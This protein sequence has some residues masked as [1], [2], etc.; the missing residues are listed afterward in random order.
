MFQFLCCCIIITIFLFRLL[1]SE[2]ENG[3]SLTPN[4]LRGMIVEDIVEM[5][6][7][8]I[9]DKVID[10][11]VKGKTSTYFTIMC[12]QNKDICDYDGFQLWIQRRYKESVPNINQELINTLLIEKLQVSF[13]GSNITKGYKYCCDQYRI[14]W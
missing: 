7:L 9:H 13:P 12:V 4:Q 14:N 1:V 2:I 3:I 8:S 6:Y 10:A 5:H 11:A